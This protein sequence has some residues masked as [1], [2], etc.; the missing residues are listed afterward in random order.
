MASQTKKRDFSR[1]PFTNNDFIST[2][3]IAL[4]DHKIGYFLLWVY[5]LVT[6]QAF[7]S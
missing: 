2:S 5:G 6:K 1:P 7:F 3:G 4:F